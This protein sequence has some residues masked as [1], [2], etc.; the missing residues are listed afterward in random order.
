GMIALCVKHHK[1]AD[2][3]N[4]SKGELRAFKSAANS[5]EDVRA[6]FEWARPRQLVRLGGFYM[7]GREAGLSFVVGEQEEEFFALSEGAHGLLELWFALRDEKGALVAAMR[8][9][10]F[11]AYP[12]RFYDLEVDAGATSIRI[13]AAKRHL[14]LSLR[15]ERTTPDKL[16]RQLEED[17]GRAQAA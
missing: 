17:W 9:N 1:M 10:M 8:N 3:G 6:K 5:V 15:S 14:V 12:E 16:R 4:F 2:R 11:T 13:R 7:G